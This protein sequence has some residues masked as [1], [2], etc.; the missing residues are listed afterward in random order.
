MITF[1]FS[2]QCWVFLRITPSCGTNLL[3]LGACF[4]HCPKY[5]SV[6]RCKGEEMLAVSETT[7]VLR[8]QGV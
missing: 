2:W 1:F 8:Q 6:I 7:C 4:L 3:E 5:M